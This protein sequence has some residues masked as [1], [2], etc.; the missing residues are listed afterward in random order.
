M[1]E[2]YRASGFKGRLFM[3][4]RSVLITL[5]LLLGGRPALA[6]EAASL[7]DDPRVKQALRLLE[8]WADGQQAY[9]RLPGVSM[10]VVHDQSVLW[11]R[12]F[13]QAHVDRAVA[14]TAETMYSIC[15]ISKLFTSVAVMQQRDAS[16]LTLDDPVAKHLPW[17]KLEQSF[18]GS[19]P[20]TVRAILTHSSGLPRE[21]D[22]PY[23]TGPEYPF[24]PRDQV[25]ARIPQQ[26]ALYPAERFYQYSNMGL[27]LAGELAA[28]TSGQPFGE[29][30]R[31]SILDPL[32]LR[33]TRTD[34]EDELRGGRL[35]TGYTGVR[36]D[37]SRQAVPR[38]SVRGIAPAAGFT[39]T[40]LDLGRFASWQF[41]VLGAAGGAATGVLAANTLRE[42]QRVQW[43]DPDWKVSR[44]LGFG[45]W[46]SGDKTF[47]GH[48][49]YC[50]GYQS[51]LLLQTDDKVATVFMTN[52]NGV[53]SRRWAQ[54]AY[55][56]VAPAIRK[57]LDDSKVASPADPSLERYAGRYQVFTA[58]ERVVLP[59]DDGLAV[60]SLPTEN[61]MGDAFFKLKPAGEHRFRRA[62]ADGT[63][64]EEVVFEMGA[65]GTPTRMLHHS[66]YAVRVR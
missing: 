24:P 64:G 10:A 21:V 45:I 61:P 6:I 34:H 36:R 27:T 49:G 55:E 7:G 38:Y 47:V 9:E 13:G 28:A 17:M 14:A 3:R 58:G 48:G 40:V 65:D 32:G 18:E 4:C 29:Y 60:L 5:A 19:G 1:G 57:A 43:M 20:I 2:E 35:A 42:M 50:P 15:S 12:G 63:L 8:A 62:R 37:G 16:R 39:S 22:F 59:W 25:L 23:W 33:D 11:S 66:N 53:D 56:V 46:R 41:R 54:R 31:R 52:T 51:E 30:V 44:G 26:K